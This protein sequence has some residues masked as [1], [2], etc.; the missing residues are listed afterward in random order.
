MRSCAWTSSIFVHSYDSASFGAVLMRVYSRYKALLNSAKT[1]KRVYAS[2]T[3]SALCNLL[4]EE[5]ERIPIRTLAPL[6][7]PARECDA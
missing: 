7:A 5:R 4:A 3:V 1:H 2:Q 6:T